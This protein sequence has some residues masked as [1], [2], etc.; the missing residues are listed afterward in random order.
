MA[1]EPTEAQVAAALE[2]HR[3]RIASDPR[4]ARSVADAEEAEQIDEAPFGTLGQKAV[5]RSPISA[6][7]WRVR[8]GRL[9]LY[10]QGSWTEEREVPGGVDWENEA[11]PD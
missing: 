2:E 11:E 8:E 7:Q 9:E 1:E 10:Y 6:E 3:Q 5:A 4:V